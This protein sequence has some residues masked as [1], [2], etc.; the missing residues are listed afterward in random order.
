MRQK[1]GAERSGEKEAILNNLPGHKQAGSELLGLGSWKDGVERWVFPLEDEHW[2]S[3]ITVWLLLNI[4]DTG[5]TW[6]CLSLGMSEANP[7]L[8]LAAQT[9]SDG[10][11][12]LAKMSLALLLGILVWGRGGR[13]MKAGLNLGMALVV[14]ANCVLVGRPLW[15]LG[16]AA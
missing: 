3:S 10:F 6:L 8:G 16:L 7:F 11:M 4:L 2:G 1:Q 5:T 13:R 12:L 15:L 9:Y 14:I